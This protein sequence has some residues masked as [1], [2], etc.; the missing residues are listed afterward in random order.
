MYSSIFL[1]PISDVSVRL[2]GSSVTQ[3][4]LD[5]SNVNLDLNIGDPETNQ[6]IQCFRLTIEVLFDTRFVET[7]PEYHENMFGCTA[8]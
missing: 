3:F 6:V 5:S 7:Y 2:F 8:T 1:F 4:V